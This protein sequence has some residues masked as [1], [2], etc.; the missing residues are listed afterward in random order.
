[1]AR[2]NEPVA[3]IESVVTALTL[4]HEPQANVDRYDALRSTLAEE[5]RHV[6]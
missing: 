3:T 2:L 1:L 4:T 5:V 6:Y